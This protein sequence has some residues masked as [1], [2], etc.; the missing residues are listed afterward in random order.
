VDDRRYRVTRRR[1]FGNPS[2]AARGMSATVVHR[3]QL[4]VLVVLA[5]VDLVLDAVI[6]EMHLAIEVRQVLLARPV[7]DLVVG[8]VGSS[9]AVRSVAVVILQELLVLAFEIL[10]EDDAADLEIRMLVSEADFLLA[11]RRVET[12]IVGDLAGATDASMERLLGPAVALQSV[13]VEQIT[14]L[15]GEGQAAFLPAKIHGLDKVFIA[16]V[17]GAYRGLCRG[18]VRARLGT[19]RRRPPFW[20]ACWTPSHTCTKSS[21]R[22]R[23][24]SRL[25]SQYAVRDSPRTNS[26]AK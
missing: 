5:A 24:V 6:R 17:A 8:A 4:D 2:S 12:R 13:G 22:S 10:L 7:A 23:I 18:P 9:V 20:C 25:R 15:F 16:E 11:E 3:E 19:C 21:S 26:I 14:S 1:R